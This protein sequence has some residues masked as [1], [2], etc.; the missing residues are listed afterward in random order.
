MGGCHWR[1]VLPHGASAPSVWIGLSSAAVPSAEAEK[2]AVTYDIW[3]NTKPTQHMKH[4]SLHLAFI[5]VLVLRAIDR[6]EN[7]KW[8]PS[9]RSLATSLLEGAAH[10]EDA[11]KSVRKR[12]LQD[13]AT[14]FQKR[15]CHK[16]A[17]KNFPC[18]PRLVFLSSSRPIPGVLTTLPSALLPCIMC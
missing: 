14:R 5:S 6:R 16:A 15:V 9:R 13:P 7:I 1:Y 3:P 8:L 11:P 4:K 12:T 2:C 18:Q 10:L 17:R